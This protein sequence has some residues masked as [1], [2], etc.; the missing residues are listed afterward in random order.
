MRE[1]RGLHSLREQK[2]PRGSW[3]Y[4]VYKSTTPI[5]YC[6]QSVLVFYSRPLEN[7]RTSW[8]RYKMGV[9]RLQT[10]PT[11]LLSNIYKSVVIA[12]GHGNKQYIGMTEPEFK[13]RFSNHQCSFKLKKHSTK[14]ALSKYI[15]ELKGSN[16]NYTIKWSIV[17]R[18]SSYS[19]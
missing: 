9:V 18:A 16:T 12:A 11:R 5:F 4:L 8:E 2:N 7:N 3:Y 13:T 19:G 14:T 10:T 15:W 17:R 1:I 6:S